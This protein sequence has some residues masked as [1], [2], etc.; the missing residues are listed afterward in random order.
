V[1]YTVKAHLDI[2][3]TP[4]VAFDTLA[5]HDSWPA[6]MPPSFKPV[7]RS[8]GT[9]HVGA[10]VKVRLGGFVPA[11]LP[12]VVVDRPHEIR[13]SGGNVLLR[14]DHRFLFEARGSG[15]RVTSSEEWSGPL[16]WMLKSVIERGAARVGRAQLQGI[17]KGAL[18][19]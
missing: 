2:D 3:V 9:L 7:G 1:S 16:A 4:D 6:W 12:I 19:R 5:D 13:W 15:T 8:L 10:T 11:A 18:R 17:E 14:G